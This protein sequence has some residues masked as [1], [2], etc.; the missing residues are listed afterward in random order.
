MMAKDPAK[1]QQ[2][3]AEVAHALAPFAM[4]NLTGATGAFSASPVK[5]AKPARIVTAVAQPQS[6]VPPPARRQAAPSARDTPRQ[7]RRM[8]RTGARSPQRG[9]LLLSGG[10]A[11]GMLLLLVLLTVVGVLASGVLRV[12]T[13][14][15]TVV[16]EDLPADADVTVDGGRVKLKIGD[17]KALEIQVAP[18]KKHALQI[19]KEGFAIFAKE[20]TIDAGQ[21]R[22]IPVRPGTAPSCP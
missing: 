18:G 9:T 12:E 7:D 5:Q 14:D 13:R 19:K 6:P 20:V 16:L 17:S 1:R 11:A 8:R 15:G 21:S 2:T 3:P 4:A 22:R 10:I